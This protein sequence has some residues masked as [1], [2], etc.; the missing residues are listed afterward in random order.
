MILL[1]TFFEQDRRQEVVSVD[2]I[3]SDWRCQSDFFP[4]FP[5]ALSASVSHRAPM[6][7]QS[8]LLARAA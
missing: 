2:N 1:R 5:S 6:F 3:R 4:C 7:L 8:L